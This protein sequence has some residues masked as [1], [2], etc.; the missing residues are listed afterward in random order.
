MFGWDSPLL[1][2]HP[3][4][5]PMLLLR[6]AFVPAELWQLAYGTLASAL[7]LGAGAWLCQRSF[8]RFMIGRA[9]G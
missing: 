4:G 9:G 2:L 3:L 5:G 1:Y 7:W 6:A 8:Q